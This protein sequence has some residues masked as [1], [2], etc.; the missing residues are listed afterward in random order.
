MLQR[1]FSYLELVTIAAAA[2]FLFG[3][4]DKQSFG[5]LAGAFISIGY[6]VLLVAIQHIMT[7]TNST[8]SNQSGG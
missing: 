1:M 7:H 5:L 8:K 6:G 3:A 2:A 4:V